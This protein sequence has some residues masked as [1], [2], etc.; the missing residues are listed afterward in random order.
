MKYFLLSLFLL[1]TLNAK[2]Y[3]F[4]GGIGNPVQIISGN[5]LKIAYDKAN[6]DMH[7]LYVQLDKSLDMSNSG[8][9]D[10]ELARIKK[11]STIYPNLVIVPVNLLDVNAFAF[12]LDESIHINKWSDL[13]NY[14]FTIIKGAKFI[15]R[16]TKKM[17][18]QVVLSFIDAFENLLKNKTKIVVL[19]QLA[20]LTCIYNN[21]LN[22]IKIVSLKLQT[23]KLYHF[24][25]KKNIHLIPIITPILQSMK[26]SGELE[27]WKK[28][29][30]KSITE[31]LNE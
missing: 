25:H 30:L 8:D 12:A 13:E 28:A 9:S 24:V 17:N 16:A 27:Y 1:S 2:T 22:N 10:G 20:G 7:A 11:I 15:E 23:L 19:P 6:I 3:T 14:D 31:E 18:K 29:Y 5:I 26:N 4:T 21:N